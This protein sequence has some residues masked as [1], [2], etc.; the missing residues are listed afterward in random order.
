ME[1]TNSEVVKSLFGS[2]FSTNSSNSSS[3]K[4]KDINDIDRAQIEKGFFLNN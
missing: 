1:Q 2:K 4:E 3:S